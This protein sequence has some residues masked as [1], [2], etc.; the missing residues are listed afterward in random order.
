M[1]NNLFEFYRSDE[2]EKFREIVIAE[3]M[4]EDGFIYDEITGKPIIKAY[5]IILHHEI[6]LTEENVFDFNISLNPKNIKIVSHKTHNIIH[7][8]FGH[9][10]QQVFVVYGSP[11]SGK[12]SWVI[13]NMEPGDL[14]VDIDYIWTC[15]SGLANH[16]KPG[17]LKA[18]VFKMRDTLLDCVKYRI[19]KWN[20]AYI[21][22]GYA[23]QSERERIVKEMQAREVFIDCTIE[24]CL[25]R[26]EDCTDRDKEEYTN[27]INEWFERF[28]A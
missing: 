13:D 5:D 1:F 21:V 2:W 23:L 15:V 16:T 11:L 3:R 12:T 25:K 26:L 20:N 18:V 19:G 27:Y 8:K 9:S 6:E 14:I 4:K 10:I 7:N 24:E 22:G 28:K 17:K